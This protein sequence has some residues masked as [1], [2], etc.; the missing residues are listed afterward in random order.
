MNKSICKPLMTF[1]RQGKAHQK[2]KNR[3]C[4]HNITIFT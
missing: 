2:C 3:L 1:G 4:L